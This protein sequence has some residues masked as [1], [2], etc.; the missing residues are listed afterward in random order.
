MMGVV[1]LASGKLLKISL[2][3][4]KEGIERKITKIVKKR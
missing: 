4:I 3:I 1:F 2:Y